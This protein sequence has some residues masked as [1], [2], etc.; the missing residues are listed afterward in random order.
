M[1]GILGIVSKNFTHNQNWIKNNLSK[2]IHRGPDNTGSWISDDNLVSLGH[3]RL[4][5]LDLSSNNNQPFQ[6]RD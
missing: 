4:S 1:C 6:D 2:I 3:T 5:I